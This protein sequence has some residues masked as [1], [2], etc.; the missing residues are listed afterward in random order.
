[1]YQV[2]TNNIRHIYNKIQVLISNN[3]FKSNVAS[4]R[5]CA[6]EAIQHVEKI[7]EIMKCAKKMMSEKGVEWTE[8]W[9]N[10][11]DKEK[12]KHGKF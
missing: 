6:N 12:R 5:T 4:G 10:P 1:M 8:K 3:S 9:I 11:W 7:E 2:L